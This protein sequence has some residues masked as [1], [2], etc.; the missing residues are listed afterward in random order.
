MEKHQLWTYSL[1]LV[2]VSQ[3]HKEPFS[4][5]LGQFFLDENKQ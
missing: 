3:S 2:A 1:D 5:Q 4:S